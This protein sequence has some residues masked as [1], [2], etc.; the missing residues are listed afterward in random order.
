MRV[1][2]WTGRAGPISPVLLTKFQNR[3]EPETR[4]P[5]CVDGRKQQNEKAGRQM[6]SRGVQAKE[7]LVRL[8]VLQRYAILDTPPEEA[9]DRITRLAAY[10]A[11]KRIA[12][13][14][15]IDEGRQWFKS[16]FGLDVS[17]TPRHEAFYSL[18]ILQGNVFIVPDA[19]Q[20]PHLK[21]NPL[22]AGPPHIRFFAAAPLKTKDGHSL[23]ALCVADR[24]PA[25]DV[26]SSLETS[27]RD[28]AAL[29]MSELELRSEVLQRATA[30]RELEHRLQNTL[31]TMQMLLKQAAARQGDKDGLVEDISH[32]LTALAQA[33]AILNE[34]QSEGIELRRIFEFQLEP[35]RAARS[36]AL[37][38]EGQPLKLSPGAALRLTIA[39]HEMI[40]HSGGFGA[41]SMP[42]GSVDICW[43]VSG[44]DK[45]T[46]KLIWTESGGP[47]LTMPMKGNALET[48][49]RLLSHEMD[50][51]SHIAFS[52]GGLQWTFEAA[53]ETLLPRGQKQP[54][55]AAPSVESQTVDLNGKRILIVEDSAHIAFSLEAAL[56]AA[57]ALVVGPAATL[58]KARQLVAIEP[59]DMAVV[60]INLNNELSFSLIHDLV[61]KGVNVVISTGYNLERQFP[62][63][64]PDHLPVLQ[65]PYTTRKLLRVLKT[66]VTEKLPQGE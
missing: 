59:L 62:G 66:H 55:P 1:A 52:P 53:T 50:A 14:T 48:V 5:R 47:Q 3:L 13:I 41:L 37:A 42:E 44:E 46:L 10:I 23:G 49:E 54:A 56:T 38:C 24:T 27:L 63:R 28:L 18:A 61:A 26:D 16:K 60:D 11:G 58:D 9:F 65:K 39:V 20:D 17:E 7:E 57:G 2:S 12:L 21:D 51:K 36:G 15:F 8:H 40:A 25:K 22:V 6:E 19:S 32:R 4:A 29:V 35:Y 45:P 43:S 31:A 30:E 33:H 34:A 64:A